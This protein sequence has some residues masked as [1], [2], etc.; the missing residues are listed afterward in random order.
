VPDQLR[1]LAVHRIS[2]LSACH[3]SLKL[4]QRPP[5]RRSRLAE[6]GGARL[7]SQPHPDKIFNPTRYTP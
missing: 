3:G 5:A 7:Y 1:V 4:S 2:S 6:A